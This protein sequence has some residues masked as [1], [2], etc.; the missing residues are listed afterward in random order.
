[1]DREFRYT[2]PLERSARIRNPVP[3]SR[4]TFSIAR[5]GPLVYDTRAC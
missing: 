5:S 1:M 3:I 2:L 4:N